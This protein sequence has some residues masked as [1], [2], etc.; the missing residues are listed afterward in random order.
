MRSY[1]FL[2]IVLLIFMA[3]PG[4]AKPTN[5]FQGRLS[6][7]QVAA[8]V[9]DEIEIVFTLSLKQHM[10]KIAI[11]TILTD[12]LEL[13]SPNGEIIAE[14]VPAHLEKS[15]KYLVKVT[16]DGEQSL[17]VKTEQLNLEDM[18]MANCFICTFNQMV[19]EK[20]VT[21]LSD[22]DGKKYRVTSITSKDDKQKPR[23]RSEVALK[24][25]LTSAHEKNLKK[26]A[27]LIV[28]RGK[29]KTRKWKDLCNIDN[30]EEKSQVT[31]IVERINKLLAAS[32]KYEITDFK[33]EKE[34]EGVWNVV[35]VEFHQKDKIKKVAF[36]FLEINGEFAL[37]DID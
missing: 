13:L 24:T 15:V 35:K 34:S 1:I 23:Y 12:G 28:Y 20:T 30:Q 21:L 33:S 19:E 22:K 2:L 27:T 9:G 17:T 16:K 6:T 37:G 25:L 32:E 31:R 36:A 18:I 4:F 10:D 8:S 11:R 5:P 26:A 29:D 14:D 3:L 7:E